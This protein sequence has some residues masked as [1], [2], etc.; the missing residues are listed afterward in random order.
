MIQLKLRTPLALLFLRRMDHNKQGQGW[1][2]FGQYHRLGSS[3]PSRGHV[4]MVS[5]LY[6]EKTNREGQGTAAGR[7]RNEAYDPPSTF[8]PP[9]LSSPLLPSSSL[10]SPQPPP[11]SKPTYSYSYLEPGSAPARYLLLFEY[12]SLCCC[13]SRSCCL[14]SLLLFK[15]V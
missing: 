2:G 8:S 10:L 1:A 6:N 14:S 4:P 9:L 13:C 11:H 7:E 5:R 15:L 12:R 3:Q